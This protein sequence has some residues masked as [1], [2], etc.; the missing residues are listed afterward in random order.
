MATSA[1]TPD[2]N[3]VTA[4]IF[5]AAPPERVFQA[6]TDPTQPPQWWGQQ[7]VYRLS[8][9]HGD[10]RVG[11]KWSSIG[12]GADGTSFRVDGEYL[13]SILLADWF[14]PG[15]LA[16]WARKRPLCIGN[17]SRGRFMDCN[18]VD[19]GGWVRARW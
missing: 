13:G 2:Q 6:I 3:V 8:E 10:V 4:E 11:G 9:H 18:I 16:L 1:I 15:S 19:R 7:G 14:I 17:S 12:V 5:I